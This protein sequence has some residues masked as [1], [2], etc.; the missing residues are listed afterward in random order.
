MNRRTFQRVVGFV[1]VLPSV[2]FVFGV[3]VGNVFAEQ[4]SVTVGFRTLPMAP[5]GPNNLWP[6]FGRSPT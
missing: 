3:D 4:T 6:R 5:L 2:L 1:A